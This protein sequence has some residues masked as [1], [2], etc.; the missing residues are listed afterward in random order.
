MKRLLW[1]LCAA[2]L[3]AQCGF[4]QTWQ[5]LKIGGGGYVR[6]LNVAPDGT[7]VGRTD[8]NGAFI[9]TG[10]SWQQLVTSTS[11]P[12][13]YVSSSLVSAATTGVFELQIYSAAS[14]VM[15]MTYQGY[16]WKST[17]SGNTWTQ[18]AFTQIDPNTSANPNDAYGAFGQKMAIDPQNSNIVYV[19]TEANGLLVTTNGG[20]SWSSVGAIPAGTAAGITGIL[21][22]PSSSV[23]GGATQGI[24]VASYGN[25]VYHSTNGGSTWSLTSS[26]PT[27]VAYAAITASGIYYVAD[28]AT[29]L[30][31]YSGSTWTTILTEAG[32]SVTQVAA[33]P[34]NTSE[35]IALTTSSYVNISYN[36]GSTWSGI[37][38]ATTISSIDIPW[39]TAANQS[40]GNTFFYLSSGGLAFSPTTPNLLILS[41]GTGAW[42][43]DVPSSGMTSSTP[44]TWLDKSVGIENLVAIEI[45]APPGGDPILASYDRPFF[46]ITNPTTYPSTYGPLNSV[47]IVHGWSADYAS[48]NTNFLVGLAGSLGYYSTDKGA[49]WTAFPATPGTPY[50]GT[51]AASSSTNIIWASADQQQPYYTTNGGTSWTGITLPGVS[52]WSS[53]HYA[54]YLDQRSVTADRVLSNT[55]YL[56]YAGNGVF[57]TTNGGSSWTNVYSGYIES[58]SSE[59]GANSRIMSVP[60]QSGNLFYTSGWL[61]GTTYSTPVADEYFYRST[62]GGATWTQVP[63]VLSVS[64]FG[65]GAAAPGHSYPAIYIVGF[66]SGV[67]GIWQ[68]VDNATTWIQLGTYP[69]NSFMLIKTIAGDPNSYGYVYVGFG[70]G[71]YAFVNFSA[72]GASRPTSG[73]FLSRNWPA[74]N[75]DFF[76]C[77]GCMGY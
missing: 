17:N 21:F 38:T 73:F 3:Y 47:T 30:W 1:L 56:Y 58:N 43:M 11:M 26:G 29:K 55:F 24:Y 66:V 14:S 18:T 13:D 27:T 49:T 28:G 8:T 7:M 4:A 64:T 32:Q 57:K 2:S 12:S 20:A 44:V 19:G 61:S 42:T 35:L 77:V 31:S 67:Y 76:W 70:G 75:D 69:L 22:D 36:A 60:G 51:I 41:A 50:G 9:W 23:V 52:S 33:N 39:L 72:T 25:G 37:N 45:L 63:N 68:S 65:F 5:T 71:G 6:G 48:A 53:F 54:Y 34:F 10:T 59:S 16:V 15:Y 62:N 40:V 74:A 46:R